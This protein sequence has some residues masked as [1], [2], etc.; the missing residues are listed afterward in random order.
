MIFVYVSLETLRGW[1]EQIL[2]WM[3]ATEG[4]FFF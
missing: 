4:I 1:K 3:H 2:S